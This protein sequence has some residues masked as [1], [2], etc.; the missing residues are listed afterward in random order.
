MSNLILEQWGGVG[1]GWREAAAAAISPAMAFNRYA[2]ANRYA[3]GFKNIMTRGLLIGSAYS[4]GTNYRGIWGRYGN[5]DYIAPQTFRISTTGL[6]LGTTG[7]WWLTK[8][9]ALHGSAL[10]GTGYAAVGTSRGTADE[11][12]YHDGVAPQA[13][14]SARLII[15]D[16]AAFDITVRE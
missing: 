9:I 16:T 6:S 14:L 13:L 4:A 3:N 8:S 2:F 11:L 12:D 15:D 5:Y 10:L 1:K 7:Q